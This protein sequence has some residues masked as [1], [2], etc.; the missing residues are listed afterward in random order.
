M[1]SRLT[2]P[3]E[4]YYLRFRVLMALITLRPRFGLTNFEGLLVLSHSDSRH[5][6][7]DLIQILS[8]SLCTAMCTFQSR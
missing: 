1:L 8:P 6:W 3:Y 5:A 4:I 7:C 2:A